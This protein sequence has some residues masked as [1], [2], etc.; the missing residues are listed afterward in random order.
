MRVI[1]QLELDRANTA[2]FSLIDGVL[3]KPLALGSSSHWI[4]CF[5]RLK[6]GIDESDRQCSAL[7]CRLVQATRDNSK[8]SD[9]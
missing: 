3:L 6:D 8:V 1:S 4:D 7:V 9:V 5:G 2:I